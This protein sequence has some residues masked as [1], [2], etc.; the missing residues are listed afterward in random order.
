MKTKY[1]GYAYFPSKSK[2]YDGKGSSRNEERDF[3]VLE[4]AQRWAENVLQRNEL[5]LVHITPK[6]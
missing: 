4:D 1:H 3:D 2:T 5:A 6:V